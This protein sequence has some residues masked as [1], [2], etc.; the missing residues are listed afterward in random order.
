MKSFTNEEAVSFI[1]ETLQDVFSREQQNLSRT[2]WAVQCGSF[3]LELLD[4]QL[5]A[6]TLAN[7]LSVSMFCFVFFL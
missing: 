2:C 1:A 6:S 7:V 5:T 3:L 4:L